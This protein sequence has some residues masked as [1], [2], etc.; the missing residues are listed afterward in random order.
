VS[1]T[2]YTVVTATNV[3]LG[4]V[5]KSILGVQANA[6]FGIDLRKI[7]IAFDGSTT[8]TPILVELC[9]ATFAT[10]PPGTNSTSATAVQAYGRVIASGVTAA[11][12]WTSEPT[13]LTVLKSYLLT[14]NGGLLIEE[15]AP[16]HGYDSPLS[17]GFVLRCTGTATPNVRA[18][19]EF[20]RS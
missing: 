6:A 4:G 17:Q 13:V 2:G 9:A 5:A 7:E 20:E 16:D 11:Y 18:T 8:A 15:F 19:M 10:N 14:P 12:N 1:K 3:A